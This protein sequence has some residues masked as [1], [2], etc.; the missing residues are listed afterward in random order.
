M[1][2]DDYTSAA[3]IKNRWPA[4]IKQ[5][6]GSHQRVWHFQFEET[7]SPINNRSLDEPDIVVSVTHVGPTSLLVTTTTHANAFSDE[8]FFFAAFRLFKTLEE[9]YGRL[10]SIEGEERKRWR[11]FR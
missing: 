2:D 3:V 11:P 8:I 4:W 6:D 5:P 9:T 1:S 7:I 10:K